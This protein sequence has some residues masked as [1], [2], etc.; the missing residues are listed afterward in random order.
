MAACRAALYA[1]GAEQRPVDLRVAAIKST[2]I[3]RLNGRLSGL[4]AA[5]PIP[6]PMPNP[7]PNPIPNPNPS[8][9]YFKV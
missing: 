3:S 7:D 8:K 6:D 9:P 2:K 1:F 5:K 4:P